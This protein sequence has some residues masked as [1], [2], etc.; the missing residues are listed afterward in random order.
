[1]HPN[2]LKMLNADALLVCKHFDMYVSINT[3]LQRRSD[4]SISKDV[5]KHANKSP[6]VHFC[7][8]VYSSLEQK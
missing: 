3:R 8:H 4:V 7:P 2:R 6:K 5:L 1:M